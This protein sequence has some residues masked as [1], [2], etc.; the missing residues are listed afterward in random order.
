MMYPDL[1]AGGGYD[2]RMVEGLD[3]VT[4][5]GRA[6]DAA[7]DDLADAVRLAR[8][9]GASWQEISDRLGVSKQAV[10]T[11]YGKGTSETAALRA[12]IRRVLAG[13][14]DTDVAAVR[15][16]LA[17]VEGAGIEPAPA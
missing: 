15:A 5:A 7:R 11:R 13:L 2:R 16:A 6:V 12:D 17:G 4:A 3:A 8:I 14:T 9:G 1:G 10:W